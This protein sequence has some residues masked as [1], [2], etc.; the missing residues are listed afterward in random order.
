[1]TLSLVVAFLVP[2]AVAAFYVTPNEIS[3]QRPI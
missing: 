2:H 3:L 1:L